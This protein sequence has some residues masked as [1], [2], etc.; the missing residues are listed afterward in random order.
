MTKKLPVYL[1]KNNGDLW[2]TEDERED[3]KVNYRIKEIV[4]EGYSDFQHVMILN[5]YCFG[6]MLVLDGAVQ[7][8]AID[9]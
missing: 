6:N 1:S 8:T 5:S 3:L 2:L 7:T 9:G 4:F